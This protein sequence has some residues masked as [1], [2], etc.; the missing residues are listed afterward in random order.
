MPL[1]SC[2][3]SRDK[4]RKR[5]MTGGLLQKTRRARH[6]AHVPQQQHS[7]IRISTLDRGAA[8]AK[9]ADAW[10]LH[11]RLVHEAIDA[12]RLCQLALEIRQPIVQGRGR[13]SA[14]QGPCTSVGRGDPTLVIQHDDADVAQLH[15]NGAVRPDG[16]HAFNPHERG[17]C[18]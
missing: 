2:A 16:R 12:P 4:K 5:S 13:L 17:L 10:H 3:Q 7:C 1:R 15:V 18:H 11:G 14:Q 6:R 8:H 9:Q